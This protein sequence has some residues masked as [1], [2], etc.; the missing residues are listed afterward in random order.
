MMMI[1]KE[2]FDCMK[3]VRCKVITIENQKGYIGHQ[4]APRDFRGH[5]GSIRRH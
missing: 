1:E 5:F 3:M 4:G 2:H